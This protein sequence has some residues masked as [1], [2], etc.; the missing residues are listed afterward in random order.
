MLR[1]FTLKNAS[2]SASFRKWRSWRQ[3]LRSAEPPA[4]K[5]RHFEAFTSSKSRQTS[6]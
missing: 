6:F 5:Y 4:L 1:M 3:A 2:A